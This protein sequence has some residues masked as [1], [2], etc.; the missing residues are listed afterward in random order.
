M[1]Y[2]TEKI[3]LENLLD[4]KKIVFVKISKYYMEQLS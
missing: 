2:L 3:T 4:F 1:S